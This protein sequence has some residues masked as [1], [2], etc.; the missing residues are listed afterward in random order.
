MGRRLGIF[1]ADNG[2]LGA[3]DSEWLQNALNVLI[4]PFHLYRFVAIVKN[5]VQCHAHPEHYNWSCWRRWWAYE[6]VWWRHK[7]NDYGNR[8]H[9]CN[10]VLR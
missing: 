4:G 10:A 7:V 3:W 6:Q 2:V 9:S 5:L 8:S 1:Y